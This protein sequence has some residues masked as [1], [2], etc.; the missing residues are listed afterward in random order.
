MLRLAWKRR[1]LQFSLRTLLLVVLVA[2][3]GLSWLAVSMQ[4]AKRQADALAAVRQTGAAIW[5]AHEL[6]P[7]G[8]IAPGAEPPGPRWLR[9]LLGDDLFIRVHS[10]DF[11]DV[12]VDDAGLEPLG[13]IFSL[14]RLFLR[15]AHV[16][17]AGLVHLAPLTGLKGLELNSPF[18]ILIDD[19]KP[20]VIVEVRK[21]KDRGPPITDAGLELLRN[22][23]RLEVL[24]LRGTNVTDSVLKHLKGMPKLRT[25][26]LGA[27]RVTD[28]ALETIADLTNLEE[29]G[30]DFTQVT[31]AGLPH[32][33]KL[34]K[35]RSLH[36]NGTQVTDA[37]M[38]HLGRLASLEFLSLFGTSVTDAGL[39]SL[40]ELPQLKGLW[41]PR[42]ATSDAGIKDL[43]RAL[44]NAKI[45]PP[46]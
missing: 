12:S 44:P 33:A 25:L 30:L 45:S 11:K 19:R 8:G 39:R 34:T 1:W 6:K 46:M 16:T 13:R 26:D 18:A 3:L 24:R 20:R 31:D 9:R 21:P 15:D 27:T 38:E 43:Q 17:D 32:L 2:S 40:R 37:G 5:F 23:K 22:M 42:A 14:E 4:R 28:A 7:S 41:P 36:L 35:L 10:I 29:L